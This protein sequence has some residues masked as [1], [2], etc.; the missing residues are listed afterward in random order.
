[1]CPTE[2]E[3]VSMVN[4]SGLKVLERLVTYS[5]GL[6][7]TGGL[8]RIGIKLM[9]ACGTTTTDVWGITFLPSSQIS[10][11]VAPTEIISRWSTSSECT[12]RFV[13][14]I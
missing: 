7:E 9:M 6:L 11:N 3:Y 12:S 5:T 1:M 2:E 8:F 13:T 14:I 10:L 4:N